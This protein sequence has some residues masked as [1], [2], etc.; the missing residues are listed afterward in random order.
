M[1]VEK[2]CLIVERTFERKPIYFDGYPTSEQIEEELKKYEKG[3]TAKVEKRY[4]L[5]EQ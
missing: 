4:I 1:L 2:Y 5:S 3:V